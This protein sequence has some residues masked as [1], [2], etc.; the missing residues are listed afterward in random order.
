MSG[1]FQCG[2][3]AEHSASVFNTRLSLLLCYVLLFKH[4]QLYVLKSAA[5]L[6]SIQKNRIQKISVL[7]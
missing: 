7:V 5:K 6:I 1:L 2:D 3:P 4:F